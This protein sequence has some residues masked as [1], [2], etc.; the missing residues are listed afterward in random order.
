MALKH[1]LAS[2]ALIGPMAQPALAQS[3]DTTEQRPAHEVQ[4]ELAQEDLEFATKAARA[5]SWRY[6]WASLRSNRLRRR[7]SSSSASAWSRITARPT[8]S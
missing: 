2:A 1:L 4:E 8:S 6:A 7:R 3:Q 5:A